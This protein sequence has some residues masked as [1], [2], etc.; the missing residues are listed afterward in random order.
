L[1][2]KRQQRAQEE[3]KRLGMEHLAKKGQKLGHGPEKQT[4]SAV[5]S[6]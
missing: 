2:E 6:T 5:A 1:Q 3:A 4:T